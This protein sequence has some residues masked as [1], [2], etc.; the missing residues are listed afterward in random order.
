MSFSSNSNAGKR[1]YLINSDRIYLASQAVRNLIAYG[2]SS[3]NIDK[4]ITDISLR[5]IQNTKRDLDKD[6]SQDLHPAKRFKATLPSSLLKNSDNAYLL[7]LCELLYVI[8]HH[9]DPK[10]R[11]DINAVILSFNFTLTWARANHISYLDELDINQVWF[12]ARHLLNFYIQTM[13]DG[14]VFSKSEG[15]I[16]Y[17]G[18]RAFHYGT[19]PIYEREHELEIKPLG[20]IYAELVQKGKIKAHLRQLKSEESKEGEEQT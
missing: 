14:L 3:S 11:V 20:T 13:P 4:I 2:L 12:L 6:K 7:E 1:P 17:R 15:A 9:D 16:I 19:L 8:F 10:H 18:K 5:T